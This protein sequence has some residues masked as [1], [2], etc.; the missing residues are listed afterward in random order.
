MKEKEVIK[1]DELERI[2]QA[3]FDSFSAGDEPLIGGGADCKTVTDV[4]TFQA[5]GPTDWRLDIE[6][7]FH[8]LEADAT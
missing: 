7:D 6:W 1:D 3:I 4:P 8:P 2:N 5:S